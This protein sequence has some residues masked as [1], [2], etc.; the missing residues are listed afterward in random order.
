MR[1]TLIKV[2][3]LCCLWVDSVSAGFLCREASARSSL[4]S[5]KPDLPK[6]IA[7]QSSRIAG[8]C[9]TNP[10][11]FQTTSASLPSPEIPLRC[12]THKKDGLVLELPNGLFC[13]GW[14]DSNLDPL[15][16]NYALL[17][18]EYYMSGFEL[19]LYNERHG[20]Y[21]RLV[22]DQH[23]ILF[24]RIKFQQQFNRRMS[25]VYKKIISGEYS[26]QMARCIFAAK[27]EDGENCP[28]EI[29][30][31]SSSLPIDV[32]NI[33]KYLEKLPPIK[34]EELE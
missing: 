16:G 25:F 6:M 10:H 27:T 2:V 31:E 7:D 4:E 20:V 14:S 19:V 17:L 3:L 34:H 11:R 12:Y 21:R 29:S 22:I 30:D 5:Q 1:I 23:H 33:D 26:P 8:F 18:G 28:S 32:A 24:D 9:K 13:E 15:V